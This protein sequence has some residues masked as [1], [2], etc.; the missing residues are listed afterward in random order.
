MKL[1]TKILGGFMVIAIIAMVIGI[2]GFG[3]ILLLDRSNKQVIQFTE[4]LGRISKVVN[5]HF[6]WRHGLTE[7]VLN[8]QE[9]KGS[10][11]PKTC[12]LGKWYE[13]NA[14]NVKDPKL[15]GM[16]K[17]INDPHS[18]IHNEAKN[19]I[20][21]VQNKKIEDAKKHLEEVILPK[22]AEVISILTDMEERY[23]VLSA[24]QG[25]DSHR[26]AN[27][28]KVL[29]ILFIFVAAAVCI[30]LA[31]YIA[32]SISKPIITI[33]KFMKKAGSTGDL[34]LTEVETKM[35]GKLKKRNDEIADLSN[36]AAEFVSHVT[37][38]S[39]ELQILSKGDLTANIKILSDSDTLGKSIRRV[40]KGLNNMF[41]EIQTSAKQLTASS[42][43]VSEIAS[44]IANG[45]T[46]IANNAQ[47][48]AEGT[49]KQN[50]S[51][52]QLSHTVTEIE[53]RAKVNVEMATKAANLTEEVIEKVE[54]GNRQMNEMVSA[55]NDITESSRAVS[56]IIEAINDIAD[57]TNMLSLNASIEAARAGEQGKGFAVV[58]GEIGT[59][60]NQSSESANEINAIIRTSIEK[61]ELG[62]R[63]VNEVAKTLAEIIAGIN[64]SSRLTMEIAKAGSNQSTSISHINTSVN[65]VAEV[66]QQN[67]ALSEESASTAEESAAAAEESAGAA[68]EMSSQA[69]VLH[70]LISR[71]KLKQQDNA[72][73]QQL[74]KEN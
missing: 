36:G 29:N 1:R 61:A 49:A 38:I 54:K 39:N 19:T 32:N 17:Q 34:A 58:A 42:K 43:Q 40:E 67:S 13:S 56:K 71:F 12:A 11:D 53:N 70:E 46:Q 74:A 20:A 28:T 72:Q 16:M 60:A 51:V 6:I 52:D 9:F 69:N 25:A 47:A 23:T 15:L 55:V 2:I 30:F 35:I 66:I 8:G 21:L 50:M 59:L 5:A 22:T 48:V 57:Q 37:Y 4:E 31:F 27:I 3:S 73:P 63:I 45:A 14:K 18:F 41:G 64:E 62:E 65:M 68:T 7:L 44:T 10:L 33:T 24:E 26:I